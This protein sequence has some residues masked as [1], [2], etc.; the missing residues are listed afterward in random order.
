MSAFRFRRRGPRISVV[1]LQG[2]IAASGGRGALSLAGLR[3]LLERAFR[4]GKPAAVALAINS[5]GGSP[6]QSSLIGSHI[7]ALS[8]ETSVPVHAFIEDVA[9]SGGYWLAAAADDIHLDPS[10]VTGSIGVISAGFGFPELLSRWGI[11]RRVHTAG[12]DKSLLDPFRPE[13]DADIV[14]LKEIQTRIH[15]SFIDHVKARRGAKLS[16]DRDL[17]TGDVFIGQ[18][19]VDL[20]LADGIGHLFPVMRDRYG[21]KA[22]FSMLSQ[23][24]PLMQRLVPGVLDQAVDAVE[25]RA[26]WS[27][28]GL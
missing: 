27:R 12:A 7:R 14:R 15:G 20:G 21:E 28:Y 1:R 19:A 5:P 2:V 13:R 4:K 10:S 8:E 9:A 17:F 16:T 18:E 24:R 25:A 22:Q 6:V 11:E 26:L 3:P 23:R